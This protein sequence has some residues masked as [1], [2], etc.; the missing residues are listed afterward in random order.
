MAK[1]AFATG[2]ALTKKAWDESLF[3]DTVKDSFF[4]KFMGSTADNIVQTNEKL[5]K[6]KGDKVTFGIRM[7]LSG[8][9][10]TSGQILEGNEEALTTY[11]DDVTL[12][13]YA[14]GVRD[15]GPLDRQRAMFSI[16]EESVAALKGW[17]SEKIDNLIFKALETSPSKVFYKTPTLTSTTTLATA[18]TAVTA[19]DS[20]I[21]PAL[22]SYAKT[23]AMTGGNRTQ[24]PLRPIKIDGKAHYLLLIHP[25]VMF[26]LQQDSTFA[27]AIREAEVRGKENPLFSG[28]FA[29]WDGVVI[30]THESAPFYT[31]GGAGGAV[32][33]CHGQLLGA[34]AV[35]WAWGKRPEVKS[36]QF[37]YGREHGYAWS[38]IAGTDTPTF[39]SL[40]YG[41]V[42]VVVSCTNVA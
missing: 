40:R 14:H 31:N 12:E 35:M 30:H 32:P 34:Q 1:T 22:I 37:D 6:D 7:R 11:S 16:D 21:T 23:Y 3:R 27:Q 5:S 24:T 13:E 20:K 33:Y 15:R 8:N 36:E 28:A 25:N 41:A 38:F 4:N 10:V 18:T 19:A 9:G 17:G 39:N 29:I 2:N 42:S 26:D